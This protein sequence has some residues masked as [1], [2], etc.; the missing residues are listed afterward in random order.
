MLSQLSRYLLFCP[1]FSVST[2]FKVK[3]HLHEVRRVC[4]N[5]DVRDVVAFSFF[6]DSGQKVSAVG[7]P[8]NSP[9]TILKS[10]DLIFPRQ[11]SP[12]HKFRRVGFMFPRIL[13]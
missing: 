2:V 5:L 7:F 3:R 10:R 8:V 11:A 1:C 4:R 9:V 13:Q 6:Q 12:L